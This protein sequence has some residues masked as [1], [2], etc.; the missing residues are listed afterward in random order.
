M[1]AESA[2]DP[3]IPRANGGCDLDNLIYVQAQSVEHV[4][5]TM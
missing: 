4:L 1:D 5:E 2:I 3:S